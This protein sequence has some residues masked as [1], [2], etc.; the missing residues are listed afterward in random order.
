MNTVNQCFPQQLYFKFR[1]SKF[2]LFICLKWQIRLCY[3]Q[4]KSSCIIS[5]AADSSRGSHFL[6]PQVPFLWLWDREG[7]CP[8]DSDCL[9]AAP[10]DPLILLPIKATHA[11]NTGICSC[12]PDSVCCL[13]WGFAGLGGRSW[14]CGYVSVDRIF[15]VALGVN[16]PKPV[17]EFQPVSKKI[18]SKGK[19]GR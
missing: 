7:G 18:S 4:C 15:R 5:A 2:V 6:S 13:G 19:G 16:V 17:G 1:S 12:D 9:L 10:S 3:P 11:E 8:A 14:V